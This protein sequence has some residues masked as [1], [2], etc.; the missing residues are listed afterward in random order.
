M[1]TYRPG[2]D[3]KWTLEWIDKD[4]HEG[5]V[6]RIGPDIYSRIRPGE[7]VLELHAILAPG[8]NY[9][10]AA[11][12]GFKELAEHWQAP[13]LYII[14]P[15]VKKPPAVRFLYE[16]SQRAF[17]NGSCDQTFM[18]TSNVFTQTLARFVTRSFTD[19]MPTE[20][21]KGRWL[22]DQRLNELDLSCGRE[23]FR[24]KS[25]ALVT[26]HDP[27]HGAFGQIVRRIIRRLGRTR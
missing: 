17:Y 8:M 1:S 6:F 23:G 7:R 2:P 10:D 12:L 22:L 25:L 19:A 11:V 21:I 20:P 26:Q 5:P 4:A 9:L 24:L 13:V 18:L 14:R 3:G 27:Q 16:W 15:D